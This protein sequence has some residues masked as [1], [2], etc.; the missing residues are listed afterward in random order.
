MNELMNF[1][2]Q[3]R[4][5][6]MLVSPRLNEWSSSAPLTGFAESKERL[7]FC[8]YATLLLSD[9]F[10]LAL[11]FSVAG[12]IRLGSPFELQ[13]LRT[14]ALLLPTY[15]AVAINNRAYSISA[16]E[17]P[18][19][20][21]ERA[22]KALLWAV[23]VGIAFL[24][25]LKA[26]V[27]F[28]RQIFALGTMLSLIAI[29]ATRGIV[30]ERIGRRYAWQF[31]NRL[32]IVDGVSVTPQPGELVIDADRLGI[33]PRSDDPAMLD[34]LGSVI[35]HCDKVVVACQPDRRAAW[36]HT[37][38]GA[39]VDVQMLTPELTSIAPIAMGSHNGHTTLQVGASPLNLSDRM[40]K[41]ALDLAIAVPLLVFL[42]PLLVF[43]AV[44]VRTES[45]GSPFF[46][47]IRVGKN[48]RLF[49]LHKFRSM[50]SDNCD[51]NGGQS[52]VRTDVRVTRIGRFIRA[53]SIDELP[54]LLNVV[55]GDMSI[56]GPRPHALGSTA[57]NDLFWTI[58]QRYFHRHA[59]K[60]G[61]TGLA[62]IRGFRGA[63]E[64][65]GDLTN[66]LHADLEY[67]SG[68]TIWR[69]LRIIAQ[70]FAVLAH[71]NAY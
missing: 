28:S 21:A 12:T 39:S 40:V 3:K 52:T 69:D 14:L 64:K 2:A 35:H 43:V 17:R 29:V 63:T 4:S 32:L 62:Q 16:L 24:F 20:G 66:R 71:R 8:L 30:G 45:D 67:L 59:V 33:E 49:R 54:Q 19:I 27:Q 7:R 46:Q 48:N 42:A 44:A 51:L 10:A 68:W 1:P 31:V 13:S 23:A 61:I 70:T 58:D 41:R 26:S 5:R 57:E 37:L 38:Q 55:K 9:C 6:F 11:A 50:R 53:T 18:A 47:Q 15:L 60:P 25:Y 22:L 65:R 56:V 36:S 34:R